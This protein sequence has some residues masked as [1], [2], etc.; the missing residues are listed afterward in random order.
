MEIVLNF[1]LLTALLSLIIGGSLLTVAILALF[2]AVFSRLVDSELKEKTSEL[3][4]NQVN[5]VKTLSDYSDKK[6]LEYKELL[7][8]LSKELRTEIKNGK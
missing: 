5:I 4:T 3:K 1:S 2:Y 6:S 8:Q 7:D